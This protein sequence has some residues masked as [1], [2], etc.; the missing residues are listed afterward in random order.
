MKLKIL[1][2]E[3]IDCKIIRK[4]ENLILNHNLYKKEGQ[5]DFSEK[6]GQFVVTGGIFTRNVVVN[7]ILI[8]Y[9]DFPMSY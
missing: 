2:P 1:S 6:M 5:Q 9:L 3:K 4:T 8:N 7:A